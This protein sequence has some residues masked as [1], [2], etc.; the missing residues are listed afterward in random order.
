MGTGGRFDGQGWPIRFVRE[1]RAILLPIGA[2]FVT[3]L[4]VVAG[5]VRVSEYPVVDIPSYGPAAMSS[6]RFINSTDHTVLISVGLAGSPPPTISLTEIRAHS[7]NDSF[8]YALTGTDEVV[9][10]IDPRNC[11]SLGK[12]TV[13]GAVTVEL[14]AAGRPVV[15]GDQTPPPLP[16][17]TNVPSTVFSSVC[18]RAVGLEGEAWP[19]QGSLIGVGDDQGWFIEPDGTLTRT[20]GEGERIESLTQLRD[21]II[22]AIRPEPGSSSGTAVAWQTD[23]RGSSWQPW[24]MG[25]IPNPSP[26]GSWLEYY[27]SEPVP[28]DHLALH[29]V[30]PDGSGEINLGNHVADAIWSPDSRRLGVLVW[31]DAPSYE[32]RLEIW[33]VDGSKKVVR[34][35]VD[36]SAGLD[37]SPAGDRL[38]VIADDGGRSANRRL[39]ILDESGA[40]LAELAPGKAGIRTTEILDGVTADDRMASPKFSPDG[41]KLAFL[42]ITYPYPNNAEVDDVYVAAADGTRATLIT[43]HAYSGTPVWSPDG[44]WLGGTKARSLDDATYVTFVARPDGTGYRVVAHGLWLTQWAPD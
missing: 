37:W 33:G 14:P 1:H 38:A 36:A 30:R 19:H 42:R 16:T 15:R 4:I 21:G 23:R 11:E 28:T 18:A 25:H 35:K 3:G 13:R 31:G 40:Q 43:D 9:E 27:S 2:L 22:V 5:Y 34:T 7:T 24:S 20:D 44:S 29:V 10:F 41:T 8:G 17:G 6:S 12:V 32:S 26:D 39:L